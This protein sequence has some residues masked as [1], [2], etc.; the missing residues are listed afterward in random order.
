MEA[1][2]LFLTLEQ[3]NRVGYLSAAGRVPPA[4][5]FTWKYIAVFL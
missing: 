4:K 5:R 3:G 2:V 1:S